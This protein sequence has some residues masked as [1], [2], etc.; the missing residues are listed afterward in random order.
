MSR[1]ASPRRRFE[2]E[3]R[4][5]IVEDVPTDAELMIRTLR[6][7][8]LRTAHRVVQDEK[9]LRDALVDFHPDVVLADYHLPRFSGRRALRMT[10]R[11]DP[12]LPVIMVTGTLREELIVR[13][14]TL[15]LTT[16]VFKDPLLRL[17]PAVLEALDRADAKRAA[18][19][20]GSALDASERRF[21][22]V[23][24]ASGDAL[25]IVEGGGRVTFGN[26]AAERMFGFDGESLVGTDVARLVP[27]RPLERHDR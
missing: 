13:L 16:C 9:G 18:V 1:N 2:Q 25:L 22:A 20:S 11:F 3:I 21:R 15:G 10:R 14:T 26:P 27:E 19:R 4:L 7:A 24:E 12:L 6:Q 23:A 17:A 5:L 8:G